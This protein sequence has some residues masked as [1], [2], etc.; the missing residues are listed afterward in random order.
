MNQP[1][2]SSAFEEETRA[3]DLIT[4]HVADDVDKVAAAQL[5][6]DELARGYMLQQL[7]GML[8]NSVCADPALSF[9]SRV[10]MPSAGIEWLS[11]VPMADDVAAVVARSAA[12]GGEAAEGGPGDRARR[13]HDRARDPGLGRRR[14]PQPA[15]QD[16]RDRLDHVGGRLSRGPYDPGL[17]QQAGPSPTGSSEWTVPS[18]SRRG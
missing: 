16:A 6:G 7:D 1:I 13:L 9:R 8:T 10:V 3:V 11:T 5:Q 4:A 2:Q 12:A 14:P 15:G 17:C 18:S